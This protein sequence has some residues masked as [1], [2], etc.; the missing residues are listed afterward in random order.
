MESIRYYTILNR[1]SDEIYKMSKDE[2][3]GALTVLQILNSE[4]YQRHFENQEVINIK[5]LV[6]TIEELSEIAYES[7]KH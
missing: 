4:L 3:N 6:K 5:A 7:Y 2:L 1:I